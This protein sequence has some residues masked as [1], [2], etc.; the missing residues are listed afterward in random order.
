[1][2]VDYKSWTKYSYKSHYKSFDL[3]SQSAQLCEMCNLIVDHWPNAEERKDSEYDSEYWIL[4]FN[5]TPHSL[6]L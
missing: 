4:G 6:F 5:N 2:G 1:M 3:I